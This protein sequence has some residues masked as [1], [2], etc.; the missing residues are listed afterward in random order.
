MY[1]CDQ[2]D[3]GVRV[4]MYA[5]VSHANIHVQLGREATYWPGLF[6]RCVSARLILVHGYRMLTG[7]V[8]CQTRT[9]DAG[10]RCA[11]WLANML[12]ANTFSSDQTT[13]R[14]R[15]SFSW[16]SLVGGFGSYVYC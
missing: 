13:Q 11:G 16:H 8:S 7:E 6:V 12:L 14:K 5:C 3:P 9:D 10:L 4:C 15:T 1:A 2:G